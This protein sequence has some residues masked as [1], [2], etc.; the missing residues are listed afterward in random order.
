MKVREILL[1]LVTFALSGASLVLGIRNDLWGLVGD[2]PV[3]VGFAS[4]ALAVLLLLAGE[5][6]ALS[7]RLRDTESAIA[8]EV[9]GLVSSVLP[10]TRITRFATCDDALIQLAHSISTATVIL[11]T[12]VS[13]DG[14]QSGNRAHSEYHRALEAALKG[15]ARMV[16]IVSPAFEDEARRLQEVSQ[17]SR[18][19]GGYEY[20]LLDVQV[21]CFLN[22]TVLEY[23]NH[24]PEV[25][26]GWATSRA[27][28][29]EQPAF[30]LVNMD[31]VNYFRAYHAALRA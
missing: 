17:K 8:G 25:W 7:T 11:N 31:I 1:H 10:R 14:V 12:R 20:H 22:F 15:G 21:S 23:P 24:D 27:H 19:R 26:I 5:R 28:G 4:L 9:S 3:H 29:L 30:R 18:S 6:I 2:D 16:D 13:R